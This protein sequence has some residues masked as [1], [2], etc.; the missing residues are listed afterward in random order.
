[1]PVGKSSRAQDHA[2]GRRMYSKAEG[3]AWS[4]PLFAALTSFASGSPERGFGLYDK[5]QCQPIEIKVF[6]DD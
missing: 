6:F 4:I 2:T 3:S 5:A 1:M